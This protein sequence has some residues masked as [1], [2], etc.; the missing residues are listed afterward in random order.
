MQA[1][2]VSGTRR[3]DPVMEQGKNRWSPLSRASKG[4]RVARRNLHDEVRQDGDADASIEVQDQLV[5]P[6]AHLEELRPVK[7]REIHVLSEAVHVRKLLALR[8][9]GYV[10]LGS[11]LRL[12]DIARRLPGRWVHGLPVF[13][14]LHPVAA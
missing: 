1:S 13:V 3:L 12:G 11:G 7:E 2:V 9:Q 10:G 14:R 5:L 4:H 8:W 6:D